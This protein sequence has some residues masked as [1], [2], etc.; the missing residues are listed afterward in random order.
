METYPVKYWVE[1]WS[2]GDECRTGCTSSKLQLDGT[3]ICNVFFVV[4]S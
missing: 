3:F 2:Q 1:E 4:F